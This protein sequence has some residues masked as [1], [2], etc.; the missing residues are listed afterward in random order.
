M[1]VVAD[2]VRV[3]FESVLAT[4]SH[5]GMHSTLHS[6]I[7]RSEEGEIFLISK[8]IKYT[9]GMSEKKEVHVPSIHCFLS[10]HVDFSCH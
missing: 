2:L 7:T 8:R 3:F 9:L 4:V 10:I 1:L 6:L 5:T